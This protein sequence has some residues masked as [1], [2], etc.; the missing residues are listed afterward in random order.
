MDLVRVEKAS[1]AA[2]L[3]ETRALSSS[4][5]AEIGRLQERCLSA[6]ASAD[7]ISKVCSFSR[8]ACEQVL[9][10]I[11]LHTGP[12]RVTIL[13]QLRCDPQYYVRRPVMR[14]A[15]RWKPMWRG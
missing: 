2:E 11:M 1:L 6:E 10:R 13:I 14:C 4:L 15:L 3:A 5:Q 12:C 9:H 7:A 8:K